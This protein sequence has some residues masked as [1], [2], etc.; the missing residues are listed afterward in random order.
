MANTNDL[1]LCPCHNDKSFRKEF[2][3]L[4]KSVFPKN[5]RV[6]FLMLKS[7]AEKGLGEMLSVLKNGEFVGLAFIISDEKIAYL[8]FFAIKDELRGKGLGSLTLKAIKEKYKDKTIFLARERLD[9]PCDNLP[10]RQQRRE[11]YLKNG[12]VDIPFLIIEPKMTYDVMSIGDKLASEDYNVLF[13]NWCKKFKT[14]MIDS[15]FP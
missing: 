8:F 1:T 14:K 3:K 15:N 13:E 7:R 11:F 4:Y 12:F 9:E 6:P 2:K 10:Q 5:E